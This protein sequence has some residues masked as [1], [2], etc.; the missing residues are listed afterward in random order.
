MA[1]IVAGGADAL[2]ARPFLACYVNSATGLLHNADALEKLI[3]LAVRSVPVLYIPGSQ[4]GVTGPVTPAGAVAVF[5][6]G[7]LTGLVISQIVREGAPF[8]AKGWGGGGLDMKT[9]VYGYASPDQRAAAIALARHVGLPSFS[10]A[11][12]TDAK[13]VDQ[14]AAAEA[15]LTLAVESLAGPDI[16]HDLGYLESGLTGSL[17][18]LAICDEIVAWLR[19]VK[20][21]FEMSDEDLALDLIDEFGPDGQFLATRHTA[22]HC[23]ELYYPTLFER[24]TREAWTAAGGTSLAERAG[25][26]VEELLG[27]APRPEP[28]PCDDELAAIVA[29]AQRR[30]AAG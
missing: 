11:G 27:A 6:A 23:R 26:R 5:W 22:R 25:R 29:E 12:A 16:V 21:P 4:A 28:L 17:A 8:V 14:Q 10:L 18:Q 19:H 24:A 7:V 30:V 2:A 13:T 15:A 1:E 20:A 3:F 9:M